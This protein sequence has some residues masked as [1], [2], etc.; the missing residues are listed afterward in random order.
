MS[1]HFLFF[2]LLIII[3]KIFS[4]IHISPNRNQL[5]YNFKET[6]PNQIN[7]RIKR[8][9]TSDTFQIHI[10]YDISVKKYTYIYIVLL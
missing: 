2:L 6:N 7:Q 9:T 1:C 8:R 3:Q 10:H 5:Q 4:S